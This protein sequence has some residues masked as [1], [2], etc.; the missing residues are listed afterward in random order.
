MTDRYSDDEVE[1][2]LRRALA[3]RDEGLEHAD[4]VAAAGEAGIDREAVERAAAAVRAERGVLAARASK[5]ARQKR[6]F[7]RQLG[8][9]VVVNAFLATLDYVTPGGPWFYWPLLGWG[10][11]LTLKGLG[12]WFADDDEEPEEVKKVRVDVTPPAASQPR[13]QPRKKGRAEEAFEEAVERGVAALLG[14]ATERLEHAL[15]TRRPDTEFGRYVA[16]REARKPRAAGPGAAE[17][18]PE[19]AASTRARVAPDGRGTADEDEVARA[20]RASRRR[21]ADR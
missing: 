19:A 20:S 15:S 17:V 2:I 4:L 16:R 14:A 8:T 12:V 6:K 1:E 21:S 7:Q 3:R 10:L 18:E 5:K 9:F 11:A 13:E